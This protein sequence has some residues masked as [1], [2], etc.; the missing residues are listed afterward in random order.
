MKIYTFTFPILKKSM[1][2][3]PS[4]KKSS[5]TTLIVLLIV[6]VLINIYQWWS[7]SDT[8]TVYEQRV[9]TLIIERVNV[10][11]EL[12]E[13]R[14]ELNNYK[15][16]NSQLDSMLGQANTRVDQQEQRIKDLI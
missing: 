15:G 7:H 12:G 2:T 14:N 5:N 9:D 16:M 6:S 8:I 11:K 3:N 13:T 10:E 4:G 1:E